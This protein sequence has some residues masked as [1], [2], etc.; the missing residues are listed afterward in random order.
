MPPSG[1][2]TC[3]VSKGPG[4]APTPRRAASPALKLA[5]AGG[6]LRARVYGAGLGGEIAWGEVAATALYT[7]GVASDTGAGF[8]LDY[9]FGSTRSRLQANLKLGVAVLGVYRSF[10]DGSNR[11]GYLAREF[12]ARSSGSRHAAVGPGPIAAGGGDPMLC[13][14]DLDFGNRAEPGP[15][16]PAIILGRWH[17]TQT[18]SRGVVEIAVERRKKGVDIRFWGAHPD[19][20]LDWGV[21]PGEVYACVEE[22]DVPSACML[23]HYDF[24]FMESELQVR[25]NK[26]ILAVTTFNRFRDGSGRRDYVTRELYY[27]S[28]GR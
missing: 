23:G 5:I 28:G 3:R 19:G 26:G 12:L 2:P 20:L 14:K 15:V 1:L 11:R 4:R 6:E 16:D 25:Q 13:L 22:D 27:R 8:I 10:D 18:R 9:D 17:N 21:T 7:D 24:G